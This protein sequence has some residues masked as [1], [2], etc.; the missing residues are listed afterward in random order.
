MGISRKT[1]TPV[2]A[3]LCLLFVGMTGSVEATTLTKI[4]ASVEIESPRFLIVKTTPCLLSSTRHFLPGRL[5]A[6]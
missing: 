1:Y 6:G 4:P 5:N 3:M 2:L